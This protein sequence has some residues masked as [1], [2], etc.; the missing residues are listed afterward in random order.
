MIKNIW[1]IVVLYIIVLIILY[2]VC[3]VNITDGFFSS[4][5]KGIIVNLHNGLGN[6]LFEYAGGFSI[7]KQLN[8]PLFLIR[9][10]DIKGIIHSDK[11]YSFL[12]KDSVFIE[13]S[14]KKFVNSMR[15]TFK[16][17]NAFGPFNIRELPSEAEYV[18]IPYTYFQ[19]YELIKDYIPEI[20]DY[21]VPELAQRYGTALQ[22]DNESSAFIHVRRGDFLDSGNEQRVIPTE[23]FIDGMDILNNN[24][25]IRDIY[26]ISNDIAWCKQQVW[27]I[28]KNVVFFDDPDELKTLYLMSQCW[29]GAVLS[30]STFSVWG[31]LLGA[32]EKT[33]MIVYPTNEFMLK[34]LPVTWIKTDI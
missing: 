32:Y 12:F 31:V 3:K 22:I 17:N 23:Y 16:A 27:N 20:R 15:F 8:V 30:N 2:Y 14:D 34:D 26:I 6:Q 1:K 21:I 28:S 4:N 25:N 33:D 9:D 19:S 29:A 13:K 5:L 10:N 24:G 11:D 7:A 18:Y